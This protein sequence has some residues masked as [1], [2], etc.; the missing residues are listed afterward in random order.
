MDGP[1][2]RSA[3]EGR[4]DAANDA[5]APRRI[6]LCADDYGISG[7]VN[8]AI[9]DLVVRRRINATSV[10]V[11]APSFHRSEAH[12][13]TKLN[14]GAAR[15]AIG[16]HLTLTAPFRPLSERY[17]PLRE[18][19]FL[20][21]GATMARAF[22]HRLDGEALRREL[23]AQVKMF[24]HTFSRAP[25][26]IDGH[27]HVHLFPQIRD[28]ALAVA[29]ASAPRAWLRQCGRAVPHRFSFA[30][31]KALL[32]DHLSKGFR[33]RAQAQGVRTNPGFAGAYEF[34]DG[35]ELSSLF[36]G[37]V[38][39]VP[40]GGLIMCHPGFVDAELAKL[41]PLTSLREREYAF[42]SGDALPELLA[43]HGA[44]LASPRG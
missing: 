5:P 24:V 3:A 21:L 28:A 11:V 35:A 1:S 14:S 17:E 7:A 15:V 10:M 43:R 37:F 34:E 20:P 32:L 41:D 12:A 9:R 19:A 4:A 29:K 27:Q 26:F 36:A 38:D 33:R 22:L 44:A 39:E 31:R 6:W 8:V 13:L 2:N 16:L 23:T 30:D 18:G 25:D 42:L 40:D